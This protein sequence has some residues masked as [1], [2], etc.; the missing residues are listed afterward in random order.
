MTDGF[1]DIRVQPLYRDT[2]QYDHEDGRS[3]YISLISMEIMDLDRTKARNYE[4][5]AGPLDMKLLIE[6]C[7]RG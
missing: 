1:N 7:R 2:Y 5:L 3:K 4:P 6:V